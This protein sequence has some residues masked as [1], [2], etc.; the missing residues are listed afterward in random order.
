MVEDAMF[1][2]ACG[3]A[4]KT[5][6][7]QNNDEIPSTDK[8]IDSTRIIMIAILAAIILVVIIGIVLIVRIRS[9]SRASEP[10]TIEE[11]VEVADEGSPVEEIENT[12]DEAAEAAVEAPAEAAVEAPAAL[13]PMEDPNGYIIPDSNVNAVTEATLSPLSPIELTY[14]RNEI[15]ARHGYIFKSDELNEYF[16]S[17]NWYSPDPSF[18]GTLAGI[19]QDNA[20]FILDYQQA[21]NLEYKPSQAV[22]PDGEYNIGAACVT[23]ITVDDGYMSL[24]LEP[25]QF[26][27]GLGGNEGLNSIY[28][29]CSNTQYGTVSV[30]E[31]FT[32]NS[33]YSTVKRYI[34]Q[35][36]E[37]YEECIENGGDYQS[38]LV[39]LIDISDGEIT[40]MWTVSP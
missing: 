5:G 11:T 15:Y 18:D 19:E 23:S 30:D 10:E 28:A 25:I 4:V 29:K 17:K 34:E 21:H 12:G 16:A 24:S 3:A 37:L 1:C 26:S 8:G 38:P 39:L 33:D 35:E 20:G 32:N 13:T 40:R 22:T 14:A 7:D 31:P 6:D 2:T 36:R 27:G 9:G